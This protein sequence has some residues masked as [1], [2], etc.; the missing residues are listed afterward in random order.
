MK[1][2]GFFSELPKADAIRVLR[3]NL[4]KGPQVD[5]EKILDYLRSGTQV[6]AV[7]GVVVDLLA[8]NAT[9]IGPPHEFSDG[10]W[11]WSADVVHYVE[12]YHLRIPDEFV[13]H[14]RGNNWVPKV[15]ENARDVVSEKW[16][17]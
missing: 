4:G 16:K 14:M 5:S 2:F 6:V 8:E 1:R 11:L 17:G 12:V 3:G 13:S 10:E 15:P 7:A 9:I